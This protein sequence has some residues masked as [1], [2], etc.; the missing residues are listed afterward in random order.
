[1]SDGPS[2]TSLWPWNGTDSMA[3]VVPTI[4]MSRASPTLNA[5]LTTA[6]SL[7]VNGRFV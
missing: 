5:A 6:F 3:G 7:S 2:Y 4:P 1:M